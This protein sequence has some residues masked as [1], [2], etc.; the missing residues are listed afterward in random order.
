MCRSFLEV[1]D[2]G[3][4]ERGADR[5]SLV[6]G[7]LHAGKLRAVLPCHARCSCGTGPVPRPAAHPVRVKEAKVAYLILDGTIISCDTVSPT[8]ITQTARATL[9]LVHFEHTLNR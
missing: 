5:R 2:A 1:A 6:Y 3:D 4:V 8:R 7:Q 9:V